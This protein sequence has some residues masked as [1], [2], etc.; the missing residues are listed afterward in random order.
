[1]MPYEHGS[2]IASLECTANINEAAIV[3]LQR[4]FP[5]NQHFVCSAAQLH[6]KLRQWTEA[7][8]LAQQA[9][10]MTPSDPIPLQVQTTGTPKK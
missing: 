10:A 6:A 5:E 4:Q 7:R 3:D 1:M 8:Q 9:V 2:W